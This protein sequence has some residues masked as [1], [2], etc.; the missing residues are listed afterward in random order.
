MPEEWSMKNSKFLFVGML[1]VVLTFGLVLAGCGAKG[2]VLDIVNAGSSDS[3]Y[4][5]V[6]MD[7]LLKF[8]D[9]LAPSQ[10]ETFESSKDVDYAV[11]AWMRKD[12]KDFI[13]SV[14]GDLTGGNK[15]T[16]SIP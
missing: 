2:G 6:R 10:R 11:S 13:T 12:K 5:E 16:F 7:G 3:F 9:T 15:Y 8:G 1:A 4:I 14:S